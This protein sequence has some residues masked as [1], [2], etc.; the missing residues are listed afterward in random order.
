MIR[1]LHVFG[2]MDQGGAENMI[3]NLYRKIDRSA[4]QFD[5]VVHRDSV[6]FFD[7]EIRN[8]GGRLFYLPSFKGTNIFGY[9][10][11]WSKLLDA[12]PE[13]TVV[14]SHI[15]S[16]ASLLLFTAKRKGLYTIAHSHSISSGTGIA[17]SAKDILQYPIRFVADYFMGCSD[18][19]GR[20]LFGKKI[21]ESARYTT[22]RNAIDVE[23]FQFSENTRKAVREKLGYRNGYVV[24]HVGRM[25]SPK[26]HK[27]LLEVFSLLHTKCPQTD[28][29]LVGSGSLESSVQ[30]YVKE[31]K[32][33]NSVTIL[34]NRKD[35]N[36]LLQAMDVFVFPSLYE[37]LGLAV[38]EAQASGLPVLTTKD[39]VPKETA[40]TD[41][42]EFVPLENSAEIW[43]E[44]ILE[45]LKNNKRES[46]LE[47]IIEA[48]YDIKYTV[49]WLQNFYLFAAD[50][51]GEEE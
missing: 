44:R 9:L 33:E 31:N 47:E 15:R 26:N 21:I 5:F 46:P 17:A 11:E 14:H 23:S 40:V 42:V 8:L 6:G 36:E 20:W 41:L 35:V 4:I 49:S 27:F 19:A 50:K 1:I 43:S 22:L 30:E 37:G 12:H 24:G 48:G 2:I 25:E 28:L 3:M 13:W 34:K 51:V 32:L 18:E 45:A 10:K 38:I 39:R 7:A 29:L 16:T